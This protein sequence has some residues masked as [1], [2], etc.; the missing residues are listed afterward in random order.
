[1]ME[2]IGVMRFGLMGVSYGG[3]IGYRIAVMYLEGV[4]RVA[5]VCAGVCLEEELADGLSRW[6]GSAMRLHCSCHDDR[7]RCDDL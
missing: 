3:F 7:R 1:M 6:L 2:E 4:E 5:C